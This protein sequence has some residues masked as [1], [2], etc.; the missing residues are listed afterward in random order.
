MIQKVLLTI[1]YDGT[2]FSGWQRQK[3]IKFRTVQGELEKA[4]GI[5]LKTPVELTG[6]SR[7]DKGVHAEG[8]RATLLTNSTIPPERLPLAL[9]PYLPDDIVIT[10]AE[11]VDNQFHC[12]YDAKNKTYEYKILNAPSRNP[13]LRNYAEYVRGRLDIE[14]MQTAADLLVGTH[15]FKAFSAVGS[16]IPKSSIRTIFDI[17]VSKRENLVIITVTGDGFL[18]NMVRIIAGTLIY[19]G[20]EKIKPEDIP[21]V[22]ESG[23]RAKAGITASACGLTLKKIRY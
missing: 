13:T 2:N 16:S 23:K 10:A 22:I 20:M 12:R 8:Q 5:L 19:C 4:L 15:D 3:N 17:D 14:K 9:I 7:T 18:Y 1:S 6:C 11:K 21:M